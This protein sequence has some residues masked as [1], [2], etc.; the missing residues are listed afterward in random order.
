[1][2]EQQRKCNYHEQYSKRRK[3]DAGSLSE[4]LKLIKVRSEERQT[5]EHDKKF[6][7]QRA[8]MLSGMSTSINK[9]LCR[10]MKYHQE[11]L[12]I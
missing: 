11:G 5:G 4:F 2:R 6:R 9:V 7:S 3:G 8:S 10:Q 1:M 12:S